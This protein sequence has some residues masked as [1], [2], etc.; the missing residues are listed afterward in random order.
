MTKLFRATARALALATL[1]FIASAGPARAWVYPEHRDISVLAV[2]KL[3][4][5]RRA[6]FDRL[7][8]EVIAMPEG[9]IPA[10]APETRIEKEKA[11]ELRAQLREIA[12]TAGQIGDLDGAEVPEAV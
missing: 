1:G 6:L 7:L 9:A 2:E 12:D 3:D 5:Q 8:S 4:P 10:L 11:L